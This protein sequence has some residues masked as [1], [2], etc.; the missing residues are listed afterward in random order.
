VSLELFSTTT[1]IK[2]TCASHRCSE[3]EPRAKSDASCSWQ[4]NTVLDRV[5]DTKTLQA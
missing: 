1:K 4:E 2:P 5:N 3:S